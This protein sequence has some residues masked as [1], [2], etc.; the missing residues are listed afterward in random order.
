MYAH[1]PNR[2]WR[3]CLQLIRWSTRTLTKLL[4]QD[5]HIIVIVVIISRN[6]C[7]TLYNF[8][9]IILKL[10]HETESR[11]TLGHPRAIKK[12]LLKK[13]HG[14]CHPCCRHHPA[15]ATLQHEKKEF[16]NHADRRDQPLLRHVWD[17]AT[18][19][20]QTQITNAERSDPRTETPSVR[21]HDYTDYSRNYLS[22]TYKIS[23]HHAIEDSY[24]ENSCICHKTRCA[25]LFWSQAAETSATNNYSRA[26]CSAR[27]GHG[28]NELSAAQLEQQPPTNIT[29]TFVATTRK[30]KNH[31]RRIPCPTRSKGSTMTGQHHYQHH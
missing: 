9:I 17:T 8:I 4:H 26:P 15:A 29:Y 1:G 10:P 19:T 30:K 12:K 3:N 31:K 25:G 13:W 2:A 28:W 22:P 18:N 21:W 23:Y 20:T 16:W 6:I 27:H 5:I 7:R 11:L 24:L 14:H